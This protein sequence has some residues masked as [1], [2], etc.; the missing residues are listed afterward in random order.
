MK[1]LPAAERFRLAGFLFLESSRT[2]DESQR[3]G[4]QQRFGGFEM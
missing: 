3:V 1:H 4:R 2:A